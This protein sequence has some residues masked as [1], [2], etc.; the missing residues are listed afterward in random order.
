MPQHLVLIELLAGSPTAVGFADSLLQFR[1]YTNSLEDPR[2]SPVIASYIYIYIY[3]LKMLLKPESRMNRMDLLLAAVSLCDDIGI[4]QLVRPYRGIAHRWHCQQTHGLAAG[5]TCAGE[6]RLSLVIGEGS[7]RS[8]RVTHGVPPVVREEPEA[9]MARVRSMYQ[10][11][12]RTILCHLAGTPRWSDGPGIYHDPDINGS[13][14][15]TYTVF[16]SQRRDWS[17]PERPVH[18]VIPG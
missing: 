9:N 5:D 8:H 3:Y 13:G 4:R 18:R 7:E 17:R 15:G 16:Y 6:T 2:V 11:A 14:C 1:G 10:I 12:T